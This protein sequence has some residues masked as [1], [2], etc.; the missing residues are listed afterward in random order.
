MTLLL[1]I[2]TSPARYQ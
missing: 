2:Q 1:L